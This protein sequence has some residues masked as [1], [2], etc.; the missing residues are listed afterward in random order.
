[1]AA[2]RSSIW[3]RSL[4][5]SQVGRDRLYNRKTRD[6]RV[7]QTVGIDVADGDLGEG[8]RARCDSNADE[9]G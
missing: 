3:R 9:C 8:H 1:M 2:E 5:W 7:Y 6:R 4:E